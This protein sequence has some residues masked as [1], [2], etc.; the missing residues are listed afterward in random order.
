LQTSL[1]TSDE[2]IQLDPPQLSFP[3]LANKRVFTLRLFKIVNVTDHIV[4]FNI[5]FD[6]DNCAWYKT[7]TDIG[8]LL[9]QS[10]QVIK[11]KRILKENRTEDMQCKDKILVNAS[12]TEGVQFSDVNVHW[13]NHDIELPVVLTKVRSLIC[14][15]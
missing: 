5:N 11:I 12:V 14:M 9:P 10:T 8:I 15:F 6:E 2:L 3:F 7:E 4:S 1:C 13:K